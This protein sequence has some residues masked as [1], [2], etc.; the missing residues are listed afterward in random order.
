MKK[1]GT[2][3]RKIQVAIIGFLMTMSFSGCALM[4][5][6]AAGGAGTA[7]WLSGKLTDEVNAPYDRSVA[8]TRKAFR[9]LGMAIEK[10]TVT[11]EVTQFIARDKQERKVWVDVHPL[12]QN[13]SKVAVRVGWQGDK[14]SSNTIIESIKKYL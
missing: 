1:E 6:A 7:L 14:S 9:S 4:V 11:D 2:M 13:R 10:E 5:G 3:L 12:A 8:A